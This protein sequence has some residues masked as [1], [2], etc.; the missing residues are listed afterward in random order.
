VYAYDGSGRLLRVT[1]LKSDGTER[2]TET[3]TYGGDGRKTKVQFVPLELTSGNVHYGVEGSERAYGAP[4]TT[5][6]TTSYDD[7]DSP[8]EV[9]FHDQTHAVVLKVTFTRDSEGRLLIEEAHDRPPLDVK[10]FG[11]ISA[12]D[13]AKLDA[14]MADAFA[15]IA[16]SYVYDAK[17]R[18]L[19]QT[20]RMGKLAEEH[21]TFSYDDHDNVSEQRA[22]SRDR[23]MH[24]TEDGTLGAS[25]D[26][27]RMHD[28]RF[29]YTYDAAGNWTERIASGRFDRHPEFQR[30]NIE[31]RTITYYEK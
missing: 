10:T 8:A 15:S 6:L 9:L 7:R 30:T 27:V 13:Q 18:L 26:V 2:I 22:E 19:Q 12:G 14:L 16:T 31:R 28:V 23:D 21:T 3:Y 24:L 20:E 29:E 5:T 1:E 11:T 4:G 17:G 25:P